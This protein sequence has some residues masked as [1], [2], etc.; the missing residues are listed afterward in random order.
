MQKKKSEW[1]KERKIRTRSSHAGRRLPQGLV[2]AHVFRERPR[3]PLCVRE[4]LGHV[5]VG[6]SFSFLVSF[7]LALT[8][9]ETPLPQRFTLER[10][11]LSPQGAVGRMAF[12]LG[13]RRRLWVWRMDVTLML[14]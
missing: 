5:C 3:A 6:G 1:E 2:C 9:T 13:K 11:E 7:L 4:S 12:T 10:R 14:W 8:N